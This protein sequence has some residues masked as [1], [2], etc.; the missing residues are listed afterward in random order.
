VYQ[1][2]DVQYNRLVVPF[3][4]PVCCGTFK[5]SRRQGFRVMVIKMSPTSRYN[6]PLQTRHCPIPFQIMR[7]QKCQCLEATCQIYLEPLSMY[8]SPP[9]QSS[10]L[11]FNITQDLNIPSLTQIITFQNA[12]ASQ[13][14]STRLIHF[15]L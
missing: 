4:V 13:L 9:V 12:T 11:H 5:L 10:H 14:K 3:N 15:Y 1:F 8:Q 2:S 7:S 6:R